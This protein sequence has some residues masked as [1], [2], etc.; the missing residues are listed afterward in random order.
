[1]GVSYSMTSPASASSVGGTVS[2]GGLQIDQEIEFGRLSDGQV[3]RLFAFEN[4]ADIA[5]GVLVALS[6]VGTVADQASGDR[7]F[8]ELIDRR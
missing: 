4:A 5:A 8:A 3:R 7:V 1:M 6:D 2:S